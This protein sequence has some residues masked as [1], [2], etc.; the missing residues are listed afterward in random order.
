MEQ[1]V[2]VHGQHLRRRD[3]FICQTG[4]WK[5]SGS[6]VAYN[7]S[8]AASIHGEAHA[9]VA[10]VATEEG[11]V[12]DGRRLR[13]N[14]LRDKDVGI[15]SEFCRCHPVQREASGRRGSRAGE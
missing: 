6:C 15:G 3:C 8:V 7:V 2:E 11:D 14:N 10:A 4:S 5:V 1:V 12:T 9:G 13:R